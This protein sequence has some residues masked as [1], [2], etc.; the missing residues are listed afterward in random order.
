MKRLEIKMARY[1]TR[2]AASWLLVILANYVVRGQSEASP[3]CAS[4][5]LVGVTAP[6]GQLIRGLTTDSFNAF[7]KKQPITISSVNYDRGE[8]RIVL[9][10]DRG[11]KMNDAAGVLAKATITKVLSN[12]R[13][14]DS[15]ALISTGRNP[16]RLPFGLSPS[17]LLARFNSSDSHVGSDDKIGV[18]DA[19]AESSKWF[20]SPHRGDALLVFSGDDD[21]RDSKAKFGKTLGTLREGGI[22]VFAMLFGYIDLGTYYTFWTAPLHSPGLSSPL[23]GNLSRDTEDLN[24]LAYSTGGYLFVENTHNSLRQYKLSD[25][26]TKEVTQMGWQLYGGAAE[27]YVVRLSASTEVL[28]RLKVGLTA[29][30]TDKVPRAVI[31]QSKS[32]VGCASASPSR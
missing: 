4:E 24:N 25:D 14:Q 1:L 31:V 17:D 11:T 22:R 7:A 15:F 19:I 23:S 9:V 3:P 13:S 27:T 32:A 29:A 2:L 21:F 20:Q 18:L 16:L 28:D 26:R 8:R 6:D 10:V 30:V 12:A 5:F